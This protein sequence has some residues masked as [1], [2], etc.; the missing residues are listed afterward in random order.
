MLTT[1]R[2]APRSAAH[3]AGLVATLVVVFAALV[4]CTTDPVP[5]AAPPAPGLAL[6]YTPIK[7]FA[8]TWTD[9]DG[10]TEY[11]LLEDP[12]GASGATEI[13][14]LPADTVA[15][16]L[17]VFM[18]GRLGA[19]YVLQACNTSGCTDS[20]PV[21]VVESMVEAIG[22]VKA[23]NTGSDDAFGEAI[24]LSGDGST[25]AVGARL[26]AGGAPGIDGDQS[27]DSAGQAGA[28]YV[29]TR[30]AS[31][32]WAPQAYVKPSNAMAVQWFGEAL[33]LSFDGSTLAVGAPR[34]ASAATGIDGDQSD[35]SAVGAGAVY[36][37]VRDGGGVWTQQAYVKASNTDAED[38]FGTAVALSDD[39]STLA[40]GAR[41]EA[42]V[43]NGV[44][45]DQVSNSL[46]GAGAAY[47]FERSASGTWSQEAYVKP[48]NPGWYDYFGSA[49]DLSAAG[50]VLAVGASGEDSSAVED[51]SD[52]GTYS[53]GAVY[54]FAR[55]GSG[56]WGQAAY[57][58]ASTVHE[59]RHFGLSLDVSGD[60]TT[61]AASAITDGS[62]ATGID[63]D[64]TT[65]TESWSGAVHVFAVD[66]VGAW[67]QQAYVK[68]TNTGAFDRFGWSLDLTANGDTLGVGAP[69]ERS[70]AVGIG[71]DQ[72]DDP[73]FRNSGAAYV[74]MRNDSGTWSHRAY[75]KA[76]NTGV[77]NFG[78]AIALSRDGRTMAVGASSEGSAATGVGGD[79]HDDSAED[80]GAVYLY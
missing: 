22:Y 26:E 68:A 75:V 71:G 61:L 31:G 36:V 57:L 66:A 46:A 58:K 47:V 72:G 2:S 45:G 17:E 21:D 51:P 20:A 23:T 6:S 80:S 12:D 14:V 3:V 79:Q 67:S 29:Y 60:G 18:P 38:E 42:S 53:S 59:Q 43:A 44:D 35:V 40:V 9:V 5:T 10:E 11:R 74:L 50:D 8:F 25:L 34:E 7:T 16:S 32:V 48:A 77:D 73:D 1:H 28:V 13:A 54:V 62:G 37:F 70:P 55:D 41:Y 27:D 52:N 63:G 4:A 19:R 30:T 56:A 64:E 24:A 33:A 15:H 49:L 39:G 76:S 65:I 78:W 69:F